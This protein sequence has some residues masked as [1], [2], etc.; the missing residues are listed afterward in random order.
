MDR[1]TEALHRARSLSP[2][3][4]PPANQAR[5]Q[6]TGRS[7]RVAGL[8]QRD[9]VLALAEADPANPPYKPAPALLSANH[10]AAFDKTDP[11][12]RGF[13]ILRSHVT[14]IMAAD[15]TQTIAVTA[16]T[17]E[18]GVSMVA[19]N[20]AFSLARL[21][22]LTVLMV[23]F[24][25]RHGGFSGLFGLPRQ[26]PDEGAVGLMGHVRRIQAGAHVINLLSAPHDVDP[27]EFVERVKRELRP[28]ILLLDLPPMLAGDD[29]V[30][31]LPLA[32]LILLVLA[33]GRST[34]T[35]L[36]ACKTFLPANSQTQVVMNRARPH[37]M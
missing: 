9:G 10:I 22:T 35:E 33:V 25:P 11:Q 30:H 37:G 28:D 17:T 26:A 20:L 32:D 24:K 15:G 21:K 23:E 12:T 6:R 16:P 2:M 3:T 29:A 18:C 1:V 13:D 14:N 34:V 27:S 4:A 31:M 19:A 36:E 8:F 5:E 7:L